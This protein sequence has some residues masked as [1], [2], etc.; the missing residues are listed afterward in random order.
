[1][2]ILRNIFFLALFFFTMLSLE[3]QD[4]APVLSHYRE[5]NE[6]E[7]QNWAICQ[8]SE[9][10]MLFANRRGILSY[11]GQSWDYINLSTLPSVLKYNPRDKK[12]YVG[13][14][15]DYGFLE[16]DEQGFYEFISLTGD[17]FN[18]GLITGITF[19][20]TT[21]WFYGENSISRHGLSSSLLE[22]R[23]I[24]D[25]KKPFTGMF[26]TPGNTFIN[27]MSEGL[28]KVEADAMF[29][30]G[31]ELF[32]E[33]KEVLFSL[34]YDEKM[35]LIGTSEG[36]LSLFDGSRFYEYTISD[37]GYLKQNI[38]S[39][40]LS[41]TDSLFAFATLEGG[42]LVVGRE[43]RKI[44]STV[45]YQNGLPDDEVFALGS[46]N[47]GGLWISHQY[48]LTRADLILPVG[49]FGIYQ[50]LKGN[51]TTA[52]WHNNEL[53]VATSEGVFV[54]TEIK[55]YSDVD[56]IVRQEQNILK[57]SI[58][59]F[60][61]QNQPGQKIRRNIFSRIFSKDDNPVNDDLPA[62]VTGQSERERSRKKVPE[63]SFVRKTIS[64]VTSVHYEFV[65]IEGFNEKCRQ[66]VST[67]NGILAATN[68][69]LFAIWNDHKA[70]MAV[71]A[72]YINFI[73]YVP[74]DG[75]YFIAANDGYFSIEY[76]NGDWIIGYPDESFANPVYSVI[77][78]RE[79]TLWLGGDD[80]LYRVPL[81]SGITAG[82]YGSYKVANDFPQRYILNL[83]N[84]TVFLFAETGIY[85]FDRESSELQP[86]RR[87]G[88]YPGQQGRYIYPLS[89]LPWVKTGEEWISLLSEGSFSPKEVSLLKIFD[90]IMSINTDEKY[91]WVVD[92]TNRLFRIDRGKSASIRSE[93]DVFLKE[94]HSKM[95]VDL[96]RSDI[97]LEPGDNVINFKIVAP[98]YLKQNTTQYQYIIDK[99]LT[100]WSPWSST[101][102]YSVIIPESGSY[103]LRVRAKD[104]WGNIGEPQSIHFTI[105]TPFTKTTG[106]YLFAGLTVLLAFS[107]LFQVRERQLQKQNRIL[108]EKVRERTA[109]IEAQKEEITSSIE[110]ASRIQRALL[111]MEEHFESLFPDYFI[112][113]KPRD[114]VSGDFYWIGEDEKKIYFTVA[115]CTG[116]G[117]PGAFMSTLGI[118][119]LNEIIANYS[120]LKANSVLNILREKTKTSLHQT[121][122]EGEASDGM[123]LAFCI[124]HK[125][126]KLLE[127]AGAYNPLF[128]YLGDEIKEYRADRMPIGIYYGEQESFTNHEIKVKKGDA[129]YIFSDGFSD[130]FGGPEGGKYKKFNLKKLLSEIAAR[131]MEEQHRLIEAEYY[132]W[133]GDHDQIDDI[134]IIGVRI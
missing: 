96:S 126:E 116:H 8:D 29:P 18:P 86:F 1:M 113:Y 107:F 129:I 15:D 14:D 54:L 88:I 34:S 44:I 93:L 112:F 70:E 3:A 57:A 97:V 53:F 131:P 23:F 74:Y 109:K 81:E 87:G 45:N 90:D 123:D 76:F 19:T 52:L 102:G 21:V 115:D 128:V 119:T 16:K 101:S 72:R 108:E 17:S 105:K 68:K 103:T 84:D 63:N 39:E 89:N 95:G 51:L 7:N 48:G 77:V 83:V 91:T 58:E 2:Y 10:V 111:P 40:G 100:E 25:E 35:V 106:F 120:D 30:V 60:T 75:S 114:I 94:I 56:I 82:D 66:L 59:Q 20:D 22:K 41:I 61:G 69:G 62:P 79:G 99:L 78:T 80:M 130:Q 64:Q 104:L 73:S 121:G 125:K 11:D 24:A 55:N 13:G 5:S 9:N 46:D 98:G 26:V 47:N 33:N 117:V 132:K 122:K 37:N 134:T 42:V 65:K 28:Y 32:F 124:L 92:G 43:S 12:V 36:D 38:L 118:S 127:Y 4:G 27:V 110:Y 31:T 67:E 50:G 133:K 49:N 71:P 85:F 6:L